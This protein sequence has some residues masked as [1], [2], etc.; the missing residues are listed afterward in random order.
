M[1]VD[2]LRLSHASS[3]T[4]NRTPALHCPFHDEQFIRVCLNPLCTAQSILCSGCML[5]DQE[6]CQKHKSELKTINDMMHISEIAYDQLKSKQFKPT[7]MSSSLAAFLNE[8]EA[9]SERLTERYY[10]EIK[11]VDLEFEALIKYFTTVCYKNRDDVKDSIKLQFEQISVNYSHVMDKVRHHYRILTPEE[12]DQIYPSRERLLST[13]ENAAGLQDL[14]N[15]IRKIRTDITEV[16]SPNNKVEESKKRLELRNNLQTFVET[17]ENQIKSHM[18]YEFVFEKESE[19]QD[20]RSKVDIYV[21]DFFKFVKDSIVLP[22]IIDS[23]KIK[24]NDDLGAVRHKIRDFEV[25]DDATLPE[26]SSPPFLHFFKQN[27]HSL[28]VYHLP[29]KRNEKVNVQKIDLSIDFKIPYEHASIATPQGNL[30][31]AGG[32]DYKTH[33]KDVFE[34]VFSSRTFVRIRSMKKARSNHAI[35]YMHNNIY[36]VGGQ[37][38]MGYLR[39]CERY[40]MNAEKWVDIAPLSRATACSTIC[41]FQNYCLFK[42]G[43]VDG[44]N[45]YV[46]LI[47]KYDTDLNIWIPIHLQSRLV[48]GVDYALGESS[49]CIQLN[50]NQ[51]IIFGGKYKGSCLNNCFLF[52]IDNSEV[53]SVESVRLPFEEFF[54]SPKSVVVRG[55][56]LTCL[57]YYM[58][59]V[60]TFNGQNWNVLN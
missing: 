7:D 9:I 43:G 16:F 3:M 23:Q 44:K 38:Q 14:E 30:F 53:R 11:K 8:S 48:P 24:N 58:K 55:G 18:D 6:H 4:A 28:F 51:I 19:G 54:K 21:Q 52:D 33:F 17:V 10:E 22:T 29:T 20:Y 59:K 45:S 39:E 57:S 37:D 60:I 32:Q 25:G 2:A 15:M 49:E 47:E 34:F 1:S 42:F 27:T 46:N 13:L 5:D 40:D 12:Q 50:R 26:N 35:C 31:L 41:S 56:Y 36:V